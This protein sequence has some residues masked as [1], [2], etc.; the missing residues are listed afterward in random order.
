MKAQD[1][2]RIVTNRLLELERQKEHC[3]KNDLRTNPLK[4]I[5][6]QIAKSE[7]WLLYL[8]LVAETGCELSLVVVPEPPPEKN[9]VKVKKLAVVI[10]IGETP[11]K[12]LH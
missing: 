2:A 6:K 12:D 3:L 8:G 11:P 9:L 7:H 4:E 5:Y 10:P 1:A